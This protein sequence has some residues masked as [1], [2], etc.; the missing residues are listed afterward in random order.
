MAQGIMTSEGI[1]LQRVRGDTPWHST[2]VKV[3]VR[4]YIQHTNICL[5]KHIVMIQKCEY[6]IS[7]Y[8]QRSTRVS[9]KQTANLAWDHASASPRQSYRL[10][11]TMIWI[12]RFVLS[13]YKHSHLSYEHRVIRKL[14][15]L[16][17]SCSVW[18]YFLREQ[19]VIKT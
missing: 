2:R 12:T 19:T 15:Y 4:S 6:I 5:N 13:Q 18:N 14:Q 11:P 16:Y 8:R 10:S 7:I 3:A 9:S 1:A 17:K